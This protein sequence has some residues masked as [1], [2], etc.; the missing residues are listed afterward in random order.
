[1][2]DIHRRR[3]LIDGRPRLVLAGE[4]HYFR[5]DRSDGA[6]RIARLRAT[7]ANPVA[8]YIPWLVHELPDG[9]FDL[10]GNTRPERDL[11]AFIDLCAE[12]WM[13]F[14]ARPGPFQM[15]ELKNEGLPYRVYRDHPEIVPVGWDGTPAP[16]PTVDYLSP[17]FLA[18]AD[19]WYAAV[20]PL[21]AERLIG[22]GVPFIGLQPDNEI[23]MLAW[24]S[25]SPDLTDHLLGDL[26]TWI[27]RHR[28]DAAAVYPDLDGDNAAWT[29]AVR[30]PEEAWAGPLRVDLTRFM[31]GRFAR[32][33]EALRAS[34][35]RYGMEGVP[36]LINIHGSEGGS[37]ESFPIGISQLSETYAGRPGMLSGS[38]HYVGDLTLDT[39]TDTYVINALQQAVH[40]D[41]Q[42]LTSLE[43]EAGTGDYG[44]GMERLAEPA[45]AGLK[46]RLFVARGNRLL[47]Y[48]LFTGGHNPLLD[49]PVGDGNDR[50]PITGHRHGFA[51]PNWPR[52]AGLPHPGPARRDHRAADAARAPPGERRRGAGRPGPRCRS[53]LLRHRVRPP[54]QCGHAGRGRGPARP[55]RRRVAQGPG[56]QRPAAR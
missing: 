5:L 22:H 39:T 17:A 19:R 27:R 11:A 32:Y 55:S 46:S 40:D 44:D 1:M 20:I 42:P 6:D 18:E 9:S 13:W 43:F 30:S 34:A 49:A 38:D 51:A 31:R 50:I 53:G 29:R 45:T 21:L 23:G 25:N 26:R 2:I 33:V 8:S 7:G 24:V 4:I 36:F 56:P 54:P 48:Y 3:I 47:N 37:A 14:L 10:D 41:D 16:T 12:H 15:A 28:E 52:G 35:E